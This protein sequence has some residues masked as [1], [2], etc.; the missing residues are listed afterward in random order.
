MEQRITESASLTYHLIKRGSEV[1]LKTQEQQTPFGNS[2]ADLNNIMT[3][4]ATVGLETNGN[5]N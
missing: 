1:S 5:N 3:Y 4:L 2:E